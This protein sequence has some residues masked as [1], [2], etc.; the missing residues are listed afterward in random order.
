MAVVLGLYNSITALQGLDASC[1]MAEEM[2]QPKKLIPRILYIT[3]GTQFLVGV[4]W[5]LTVSFSIIDIDDIIDTATGLVS[6]LKSSE[7]GRDKCG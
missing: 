6:P 5:I 7:C 2:P 4:V 1:H 3:I